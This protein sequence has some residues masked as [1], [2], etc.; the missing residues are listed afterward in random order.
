LAQAVGDCRVRDL[1]RN[2]AAEK[3]NA[4]YVG[5]VLRLT[6]LAPEIIEAILDGRQ[7]AEMT[8]AVL[9]RPFAVEWTMAVVLYENASKS[10][11]T[12]RQ[13]FLFRFSA[14]G[15]RSEIMFGVLIV[16]LRPD[17][18]AGLGLSLG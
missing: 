13:L 14:R 18:I 5:R 11:H 1:R 7:P 12:S 4:S 8:L 6:L 16:V 17:P 2:R 3:I 15:H 10:P 9:M